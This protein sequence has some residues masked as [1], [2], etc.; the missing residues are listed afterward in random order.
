LYSTPPIWCSPVKSVTFDHPKYLASLLPTLRQYI[1]LWTLLRSIMSTVSITD[2]EANSPDGNLV[3]F[4][5]RMLEE[6]PRR[7][8]VRKNN[9][10]SCRTK[11]KELIRN[12]QTEGAL[13]EQMSVGS[14]IPASE[15]TSPPLPIDVSLS[16]TSSTPPRPKLDVIWPLQ[17]TQ[18]VPTSSSAPR[19]GSVTIEIGPDGEIVIPASSGIPWA[20]SEKGRRAI[21]RVIE[22]GE[23]LSL[24]VEWIVAKLRN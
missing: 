1:L 13:A 6:S 2:K 23:D 19:F 15:Q 17:T 4:K 21:A 11:V 9:L 8:I 3:A 20:D 5:A 22:L 7:G 14:A 12:R 24:L 10:D 18:S 16:L